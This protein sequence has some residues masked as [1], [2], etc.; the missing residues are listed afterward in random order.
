MASFYGGLS[1]FHGSKHKVLAPIPFRVIH[2][3]QPATTGPRVEAYKALKKRETF[4]ESAA[5]LLQA[6]DSSPVQTLAEYGRL[7]QSMAKQAGFSYLT[8]ALARIAQIAEAHGGSAKPSGAGGGDIAVA[9]IPEEDARAAFV[10]A[11]ASE[12]LPEIALKIAPG[13][14]AELVDA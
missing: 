10:S 2:S 13:L 14:H 1:R 4:L 8:P 11:C 7:L 3:G 12:G 9:L 6:F 5:A